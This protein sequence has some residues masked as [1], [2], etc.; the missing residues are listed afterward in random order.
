MKE[1]I[2]RDDVCAQLGWNRNMPRSYTS[3]RPT[4]KR[5][6]KVGGY[7]SISVLIIGDLWMVSDD[8]AGFP[9]NGSN[10]G[11]EKS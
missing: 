1:E 6:G 8:L 5:G 9:S 3:F 10:T 4:F 7:A 2:L 11:R